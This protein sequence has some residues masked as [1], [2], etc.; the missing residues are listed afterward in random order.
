MLRSFNRFLTVAALF[1]LVAAGLHAEPADWI[2]TARYVVTMDA[3]HRLIDDG[4]IAIRA[5][6]IVAVGKRADIEQQFQSKQRLERPNALIMP[7][8]IHTHTHAALS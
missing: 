2:Y 5:D 3:Q 6:K 7:G 1:L 4:A 8:L